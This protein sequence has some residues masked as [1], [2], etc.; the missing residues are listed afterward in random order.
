MNFVVEQDD[1]SRILST[2]LRAIS[3]LPW[4]VAH[5][6]QIP[7]KSDNVVQLLDYASREGWLL[8][9]G[10]V[11][12]PRRAI[13]PSYDEL[14]RSL[15][16]RLRTSVRSARRDLEAK[17]KLEFG[18]YASDDE[19]PGALETLYRNHA[20]RWQAKG[21][22][23]VFVDDRKRAFYSALSSKLLRA[24]ALRFYYLKLNGKVVAQQ[25]CFEHRGTVMLLQEGFDFEF[26]KMN[27]GNVLRV[28]VFEHLISNGSLVYDFLAGSSRHKQAWSDGVANDLHVRACRPSIVGKLA[29]HVPR[30]WKRASQDRASMESGPS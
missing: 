17:H 16:S 9:R 21:E 11:A 30:W 24:G 5:F 19:L 7:E 25:Y 29:F 12:C 1:R 4:D 6:N 2:L 8:D 18:L 3:T 28:L 15:P 23:G 26:A 27:V 14:L 22:R 13:P 20:G 10:E